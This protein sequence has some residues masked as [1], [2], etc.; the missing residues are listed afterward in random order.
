[1]SPEQKAQIARDNGAKSKGPKS[2]EG[3]A[4]SSRNALKDGEY[5]QKLAHLTPAHEAVLCHEDRHAFIDLVDELIAIYRPS[6]QISL[7]V[8]RDM[9]TDRWQIERLKRALTAHWNLIL[10]NASKNVT[11]VAPEL[12][13]LHADASAVTELLSGDQFLSRLNREIVRLKLSLSQSERRLKFIAANYPDAA[14]LLEK[15]TND[16]DDTNVANTEVSNNEAPEST[17]NEPPLYITENIPSVIAYYKKEFP[18]REII[19]LPPSADSG[20]S[21]NYD[22]IPDVPRKRR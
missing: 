5:A 20:D 16:S 9:A 13:Q 21:Y 22:D 19:V 8:I 18:G 4:N 14:P 3:K 11:N 15:Q 7:A 10:L 1:M 6:N 17:K 2:E 12:H